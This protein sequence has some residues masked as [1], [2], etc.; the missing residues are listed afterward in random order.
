[1]QCNVF[2]CHRKAY[3][4][5][6]EVLGLPGMKAYVGHLEL[7]WLPVHIGAELALGYIATTNI[8]QVLLQVLAQ[9][10]QFLERETDS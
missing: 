9:G 10:W 1:M 4:K 8:G 5:W 2:S 7:T 6:T 3:T